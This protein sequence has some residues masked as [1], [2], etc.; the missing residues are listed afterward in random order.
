MEFQGVYG[1]DSIRRRDCDVSFELA[2]LMVGFEWVR[3]EEYFS[4]DKGE[5]ERNVFLEG[6]V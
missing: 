4:G 3:M 1:F 5:I 6:R 2:Q